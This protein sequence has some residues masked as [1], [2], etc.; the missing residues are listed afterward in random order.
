MLR[1]ITLTR[2]LQVNFVRRDNTW[3]SK[4]IFSTAEVDALMYLYEIEYEN[5]DVYSEYYTDYLTDECNFYLI[6]R[7]KNEADECEF[8]IRESV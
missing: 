1:T 4:Q 7:F 8:I 3:V 5:A 2:N 6:I